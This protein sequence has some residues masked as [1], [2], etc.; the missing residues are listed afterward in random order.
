[1]CYWSCCADGYAEGDYRADVLYL[2]G[3][4][5][6]F[7]SDVYFAE[8]GCCCVRGHDAGLFCDHA[9]DYCCACGNAYY[10]CAGGRVDYQT[11]S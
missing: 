5:G 7:F 10:F 3:A 4:C 6:D 8:G 11:L 9:A 2:G 1:M